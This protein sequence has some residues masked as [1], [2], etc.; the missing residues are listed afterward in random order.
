MRPVDLFAA[1]VLLL[2]SA[3]MAPQHDYLLT[4]VPCT[5]VRL[6]DG[7]WSKRLETN[8]RVTIPFAFRQCEST[9]RVDNFAIACKLKEGEQSGIFPFDDS[10]VYKIIEGA[11][12]CLA[13]APDPP[14][15]RYIDSLVTLIAGA[16]EADGYLYT[17]R[18][19]R[20]RR[21]ARWA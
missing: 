14:L 21:L 2:G 19:N 9:G 18:S 7:F 3:G 15:E 13:T 6:D 4:P 20:S 16:Q 1:S 5:A 10:D 12:Y 17:A 11:S 8:R